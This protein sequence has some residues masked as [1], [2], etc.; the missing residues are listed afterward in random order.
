MQ[1]K[2]HANLIAVFLIAAMALSAPSIATELGKHR[3]PNGI[4]VITEPAEWNPAAAC[5]GPGRPSL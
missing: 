3:L 2:R 1:T 5:R 4:T